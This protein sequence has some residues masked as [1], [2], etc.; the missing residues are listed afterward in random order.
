MSNVILRS[1]LPLVIVLSCLT[2]VTYVLAQEAPTTQEGSA[3]KPKAA[4]ATDFKKLKELLPETVASLKRSGAEGSKQSVGEMKI[5]Q[6]RGTYGE[7]DKEA[8]ASVTIIDY[9][10]MPGMANSVAPWQTLEIDNE[11]DNDY[12]RTVTINGYK[13]IENYNKESKS[14]SLMLMVGSRFMVTIEINSLP[15]DTLKKAGETLKL[16][17][18]EAL[19]K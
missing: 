3:E 4:E 16:K 10:A 17:E 14:G 9:G 11:S 19:A 6:A 15:A 18:L 7:E 1:S 8:N 13:A 5:S 2:P 12:S